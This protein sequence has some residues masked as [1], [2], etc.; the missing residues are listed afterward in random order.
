MTAAGGRRALH[1]ELMR[2]TAP[3]AAL[4]FA[5]SGAVM[6]FNET[7]QWAGRWAPLAEYV[8]VMLI[9]LVPLA[10][11][12]GTWQAGRE[13]RRRIV[14]LLG[15]TPRPRWQQVVI[16]WAA[17]TIGMSAGLLA[18]WISGAVLVA[19]VA[20]YPGRNWWWTLIVAIL[21]LAAGSAIGVAIGSLIPGR[22]VAP[23]VGL[24]CYVVLGVVAYQSSPGYTWLSPT[25]GYTTDGGQYLPLSFQLLQGLWLA[26]LTATILVLVGA[27]QKLWALLP[28]GMAVAAA[29]PIVSGPGYDRWISDPVAREPTCVAGPPEVCLARINAFLLDEFAPRAQAALDRWA[30]V[31]G[32]FVR[33]VDSSTRDEGERGQWPDRTVAVSVTRYATAVGG[34]SPQDEYEWKLTDEFASAAANIAVPYCDEFETESADAVQAMNVAYLWA[35]GEVPAGVIGGEPSPDLYLDRL[36]ALPETEQKAWMGRYLAASKKC[37]DSAM[38][39]LVAELASSRK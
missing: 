25:L 16:A 27:R 26:A 17:V 6:L 21:G 9:V 3:Y 24:A 1:T 18:V 34:L 22:I 4:A 29:I 15:S 5:A 14:E 10:V 38:A 33:A 19:P 23:L 35:G 32:G 30:G 37:D 2:G 28:A 31:P 12:A 7:E 39:E 11:A 20:T 13:R 36:L 8:R